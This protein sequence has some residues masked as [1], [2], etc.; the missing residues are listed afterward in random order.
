MNTG[1]LLKLVS[2]MNELSERLNDGIA[3]TQSIYERLPKEGLTVEEP[4]DYA[5]EFAEGKN[6]YAGDQ[7]SVL[8]NIRALS[9]D[10]SADVKMH[11]AD[12]TFVICIENE[13]FTVTKNG[14]K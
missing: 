10:I 14:W 7:S 12:E 4:E 3:Y 5:Y 2:Y 8:D 9:G 11:L 1:K 6:I 13:G